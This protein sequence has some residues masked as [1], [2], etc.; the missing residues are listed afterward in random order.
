M[1]LQLIAAHAVE[2]GAVIFVAIGRLPSQE[3][4]QNDAI[5]PVD[6]ITFRKLLE[7]NNE[8]CDFCLPNVGFFSA[9]S[10]ANDFGRHP[11]VRANDRHQDALIGECPA[12]AKIGDFHHVV[13]I[14]QD[15]EKTKQYG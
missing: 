9:F 5:R 8:I 11:G 6:S 15:T 3:L 1:Q 12:C 4:P 13:G 7:N 10:F 14:Q 2:D